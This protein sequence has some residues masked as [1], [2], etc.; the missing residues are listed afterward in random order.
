[1]S[2][3]CT[4]HMYE[5]KLIRVGKLPVVISISS[6]RVGNEKNEGSQIFSKLWQYKGILGQTLILS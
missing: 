3:L 2:K 5:V 4:V 1:M 6:C